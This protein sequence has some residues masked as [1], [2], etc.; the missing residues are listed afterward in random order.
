VTWG[1]DAESLAATY[2]FSWSEAQI[3]AAMRLVPLGQTQAQ[4][5]IATLLGIIASQLG[6]ALA[7]ADDEIT[8]TIPGQ[9]LCSAMH[10]TLYTRLFRS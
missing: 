4:A 1:L 10:E 7:L 3:G 5:V 6:S 2:C 9:A 8:S